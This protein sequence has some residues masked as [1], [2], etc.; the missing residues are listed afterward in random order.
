MKEARYTKNIGDHFD[1]I[2]LLFNKGSIENL[3]VISISL[4]PLQYDMY[5]G[6][7]SLFWNDDAVFFAG[8]SYGLET[9]LQ[10]VK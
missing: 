8:Y 4:G 6:N 2:L 5:S 7:N 10:T 1:T 9:F 3:K